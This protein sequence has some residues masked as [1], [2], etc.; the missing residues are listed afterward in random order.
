MRSISVCGTLLLTSATALADTW[1]DTSLL[2]DQPPAVE[3][4]TSALK[5]FG[6]LSWAALINLVE[7]DSDLWGLVC[8]ISYYQKRGSP[9]GLLPCPLPESEMCTQIAQWLRGKRPLQFWTAYLNKTQKELPEVLK[10]DAHP[11]FAFDPSTGNDRQ[12]LYVHRCFSWEHM[13]DCS[14]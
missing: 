4:L 11:P 7:S 5:C 10:L 14:M 1:T 9:S 8:T 3:W 2:K 6:V 13:T 12:R